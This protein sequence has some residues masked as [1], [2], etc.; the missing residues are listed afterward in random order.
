[1]RS[2]MRDVIPSVWVGEVIT[3]TLHDVNLATCWPLAVNRLCRQHPD[4]GPKPVAD[5]EFG[6]YFD[7]SVFDG[8]A[9]LCVQAC[10]LYGVDD[11]AVGDVG[12]DDA[13]VV[14]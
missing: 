3:A 14:V 5:G 9:F 11:G 6:C 7:A 10:R 2:L 1:V 8:S 4:S 13:G 12:G